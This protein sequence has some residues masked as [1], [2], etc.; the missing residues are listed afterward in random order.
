[1][2]PNFYSLLNR[3]NWKMLL[4]FF[5]FAE[6]S[7]FGQTFTQITDATNPIVCDTGSS[8]GGSWIDI[9]NDGLLDLFVANG[10]LSSQNNSL[11]LNTGNGN[12]IKVKSG[13]IVN[14]GGSS[15]GSTWADYDND[16][17]LDCFVTNRNNFGNFLYHG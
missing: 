15:I 1:M 9:N 12:F 10:N 6:H 17:F 5:M 2:K 14:D 11:Y 16:G 7:A 3:L 4:A 8:G 13:N